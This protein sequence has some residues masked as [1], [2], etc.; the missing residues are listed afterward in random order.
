[1]RLFSQNPRKS[2]YEKTQIARSRAKFKYCKVANAHV[3]QWA[4]LVFDFEPEFTG[5]ICCMGTRNGREIDL[6]RLNFFRR[7]NRVLQHLISICERR[8]AGWSDLIG[9]PLHWGRSDLALVTD[10][11]VFGVEINPDAKRADTL[12]GSFDDLPKD[13]SDT[14][15]LIYTNS[16]DQ[17]RDPVA[18]ANEWSRILKPSGL[19]LIGFNDSPPS[20][21][22]PTG[23]LQYQDLLD[24]FPGEMLYYNKRGSNYSDILI[25]SNKTS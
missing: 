7:E 16:F 13:W 18:T 11:S 12:I 10:K 23:D 9:S 5:P 22:D 8:K 19:V 1:M 24:L 21:T 17:S 4:D 20:K 14:F 25:R 15:S 6:F 3:R 2:E